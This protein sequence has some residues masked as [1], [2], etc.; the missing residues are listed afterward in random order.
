MCCPIDIYNNWNSLRYPVVKKMF[1]FIFFPDIFI[2]LQY[3]QYLYKIWDHYQL[4]VDTKPYTLYNI[5]PTY[6]ANL[7]TN[8]E[9]EFHR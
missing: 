2:R 3:Q 6:F 9:V 5:L 7:D 4:F 1:L 8:N